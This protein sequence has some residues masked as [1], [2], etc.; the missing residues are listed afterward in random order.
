MTPTDLGSASLKELRRWRQLQR[1]PGTLSVIGAFCCWKEMKAESLEF[2]PAPE[3]KQRYHAPV[4]H[5]P[6][7]CG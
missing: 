5:G 4:R 2:G 3:V 1:P 6:D 7:F